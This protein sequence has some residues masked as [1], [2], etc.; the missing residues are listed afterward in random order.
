[1][2]GGEADGV[3]EGCE[4]PPV[5]VDTSSRK[6]ILA[7]NPMAKRKR[8]I[9][10]AGVV[11]LLA[12]LV[13]PLGCL[14][15]QR[16][17]N[18][19]H[20]AQQSGDQWCAEQ[21]P[22]GSRPFCLRGSCEADSEPGPRPRDGCV[23]ARP[24]D[25]ACY[26]PCGNG[27]SVLEDSSCSELES[28]EGSGSTAGET[29]VS[30]EGSTGAE[31][32]PICGNDIVE[33]DEACDDGDLNG[34]PAHCARDCQGPAMWCG[35]GRTQPGEVCDDGNATEGDG[36]NP[37][38]R[39]SGALLW[40]HELDVP[41]VGLGVDIGPDQAIYVAG[42]AE[43]PTGAWAAR[44][45]D[46]DGS[47]DWT[48]TIATPAGIFSPNVFFVARMVG[49][50]IIA[51]AGRHAEQAHVLVLDDTGVLL[52]EVSDPG[53]FEL[54]NL[55]VLSDGYL[56]NSNGMVVR[57]NFA[58]SEQWAVWIGNGLA[59]RPD[60]NIALTVGDGASFRRFTLGGT[61]FAPVVFPLPFFAASSD[62]VAWTGTGDVV[63]AGRVSSVA[64]QEA[65]VLKS[66]PGGVL[67]WMH[68]PAQL[69][70]QYRQAHCLAVDSRDAIIVGGSVFLLGTTH[71]FLMKL[72]PDGDVLWLRELELESPYGR[73]RG[74][75]TNAANEIIAVGESSDELWV[76][77]L[78]P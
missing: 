31:P 60:D 67:R 42:A 30:E 49:D 16:V 19:H 22:D 50:H 44:I 45:A 47:I 48:E 74:C 7:E 14:Q 46:A 2:T 35:D 33:A 21:H 1:V 57:Y 27:S 70:N 36:C 51:F 59:Y 17:P 68:G 43:S 10:A 6:E 29:T 77:K 5:L 52:E 61:P 73:I 75:T 20:C 53:Q 76:A 34:S 39:A 13:P 3:L 63:V 69:E 8:R 4:S 71:P 23:A 78:T 64:A 62:V 12:V 24:L 18:E 54:T 11:P 25:D 72:S 15:T 9:L 28:D 58:L 26:S 38:C 32:Q 55:A 40:A 56:A 66:S 65:L 37:D 41:G